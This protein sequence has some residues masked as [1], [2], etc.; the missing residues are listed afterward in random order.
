MSS[1]DSLSE[2][3]HNMEEEFFRREDAKLLEKLRAL[4]DAE[5]TRDTL[6][7]ATGITNKD[8]LDRLATLKIGGE[9]AAALSVLPFVEVA[10]ADGSIDAKERAALVAHALTKGFM[11]GS[12]ENAL[13]EMWLDQ[14]PAPRFFEAWTHLVHGLCEHLNSKEVAQLRTTLVDRARSVAEASGGVLG[15]GKVSSAEAA[16]LKKLENVF[17]K[18]G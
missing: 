17:D 6:A 3:G 8:V 7:K 4:K 1:N 11:P 2:R 16:M 5:T 14:R 18:R 15:I 13:L 9:T 12:R 10:W